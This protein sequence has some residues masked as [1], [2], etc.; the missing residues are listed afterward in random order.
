MGLSIFEQSLVNQN[1][2]ENKEK[3][4]PQ[5]LDQQLY[6]SRPKETKPQIQIQQ[7]ELKQKE[8]VIL[9]SENTLEKISKDKPINQKTP[10][11]Q[12][13]KT[14]KRS[15]KR[16]GMDFFVDQLETLYDLQTQ[17]RK[18]TGKKPTLPELVSEGLELL[19]KKK[20]I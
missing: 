9:P 19:F 20:G 1:K 11:R 17:I 13:A 16:Q 5:A 12:N 18:Q 4:K 2:P 7:T 15:T 6:T 3:E 10:K 8:D 14:P